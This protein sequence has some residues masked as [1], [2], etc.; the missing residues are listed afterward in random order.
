MPFPFSHPTPD[1]Y[2]RWGDTIEPGNDTGSATPDGQ[3][4]LLRA[5]AD[6]TATKS[7]DTEDRGL[8]HTIVSSSTSFDHAGNISHLS[9]S[10]Q[11]L[12]HNFATDSDEFTKSD[13]SAIPRTSSC[14]KGHGSVAEGLD[15][16]ADDYSKPALTE[17]HALSF[18][19]VPPA[20]EN[21]SNNADPAGTSQLL[22]VS[23]S[24]AGTLLPKA[25]ITQVLCVFAL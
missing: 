23:T 4:S 8:E 18:E 10:V 17:E 11:K 19:T 6:A 9:P 16:Q 3:T 21:Q 2:S 22:T 1:R 15:E 13:S 12:L 5:P 24:T 25:D 7:L 20:N 14:P